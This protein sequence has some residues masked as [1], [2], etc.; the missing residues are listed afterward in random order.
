MKLSILIPSLE[1]RG[2]MLSCLKAE[3][4]S[5]II[6]CKADLYEMTDF[7]LLRIATALNEQALKLQMTIIQKKVKEAESKRIIQAASDFKKKIDGDGK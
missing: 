5:Q 1:S 3:L 4:F 2:T 6:Q 7:D